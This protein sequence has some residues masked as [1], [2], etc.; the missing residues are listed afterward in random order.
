MTYRPRLR[1]DVQLTTTDD[2]CDL[3]DP[4]L[5]R[6]IGL[7]PRETELVRALD[8][9]TMAELLAAHPRAERLVRRLMLLHLLE[10]AGRDAVER[11][12][13]VRAGDEQVS[14]SALQGA[15]FECQGSGECCQNYVFGPLD[16]EDVARLDAL[17]AQIR[18]AL[19]WVGAGPFVEERVLTSGDRQRFLRSVDDRCVFLRDDRRC[20]LHGAFGADAKPGLCR[21]YPLEVLPTIDGVRVFDKGS[22]ASFALSAR[23]GLPL[24]QD[25]ERLRALLPASWTLYHPPVEIVPGVF[26]DYATHLAFVDRA[27]AM[28]GGGTSAAHALGA[29]GRVLRAL[30]AALEACPLADGEPQRTVA[31]VLA[32]DAPPA[33]AGA[34]VVSAG[35]HA[36]ARVAAA[37]QVVVAGVI[38]RSR[39]DGRGYFSVRLLREVAQLVHVL[40]QVASGAPDAYHQ[41]IARVPLGDRD[42]DAVLRVSLE[43][44]LFGSG[45]LVCEHATAAL[46]RMALIQLLATWGARVRAVVEA[47]DVAASDLSWGHMLAVRLLAM[48]GAEEALIAC[49]ECAWPVLEALPELIG[50]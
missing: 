45:A 4:V 41:E 1:P 7:G 29:I 12:R 32:S 8:G 36:L 47:R 42:S 26:C 31:A 6:R 19:P 48:M 43:Q 25:Q 24:A 27:L 13:R 16:D 38:A 34:E 10:G 23:R 21:L 50:R 40:Q 20:G 49:E 18:A 14:L 35:R 9:R 28:T 17:D 2:G 22:C 39:S 15:R 33:S 30:G 46:L 3:D 37:L 11:V 44:Q 5:D